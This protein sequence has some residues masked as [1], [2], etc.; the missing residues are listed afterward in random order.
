M[1]GTTGTD[2][3][4][5]ID[6]YAAA[7]RGALADVPEEQAETLLED[8][9]EHL[10]EVAA[11]DDA[12]LTARLGPPEEYAREL[13]TAAG[14]QPAG[15]SASG[16][17]RP[18]AWFE[19]LRASRPVVELLRF[20]PELRPAWWVVRAW[21]A[22]T[23]VGLLFVGGSSFPLPT[24]G[25]G[26]VGVLL[27]AAA[28]VWSV[29][30]G[31]QARAAGREPGHSAVLVNGLLAVLTLVAVVGVAYRP[32]IASADPVYY[33]PEPS[34]GLRHDDGSPITNI[35]PYSSDG[36]PLTG[37]QLYDQDGRPIDDLAD[38][39]A[40]GEQV[41]RVPD[42]PP[43]LGN[44]YPQQREVVVFGEQGERGVPMQVPGV[45]TSEPTL[46]GSATSA[47]PSPAK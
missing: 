12:P 30:L 7:V 3:R 40:D 15:A 17:P 36:E 19:A 25:L 26:I 9:E 32:S 1:N 11:D 10:A 47:A 34:Q 46:P 38:T 39:T 8:L 43:Q 21:G 42:A 45:P 22:A 2:R 31:R 35:Y 20:L 5:E 16:R 18:A 41:R 28:V 24:L 29:R 27:T 33:E 13:R 4:A 44:V 6:A 14:L 23:A 37:V